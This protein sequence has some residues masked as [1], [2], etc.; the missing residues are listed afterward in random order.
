[1]VILALLAASAAFAQ[2][3]QNPS[4]M[5]EHRRPHPRLTEQHPPGRREA[6]SLGT[7]FVPGKSRPRTLLFFFHGG[8]WLPEVAAAKRHLAV[9][10][11]QIGAGSGVYSRAFTDP[12]RFGKLISE[13]EAKS[14]VAYKRILLAG[15][16]AGNGAI[17]TILRDPASY[18]RVSAILDIDGMHA[19]YINGKPDPRDLDIWAK[20][21]ADAEAGKKRFLI[22]HSEIYPGTFAST[23][24]T[25]DWLLDEI[26]LKAR[27]VLRHGP[28]G[29]QQL[30]EAKKGKFLLRGYA[31][32][33]APDHVDQLH[34]LPDY[35]RWLLRR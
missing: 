3:P 22:T 34:S 19:G 30:S 32:N 13:A 16:S 23:T 29:T 9:V 21:S 2:M 14:G 26:H 10:T 25:A 18:Q 15:W 11:I 12:A 33:S 1:M 5:V 8:T 27:P 31:G 17:R 35:L 24:E 20:L 6:L 7:L 28:M 4:P